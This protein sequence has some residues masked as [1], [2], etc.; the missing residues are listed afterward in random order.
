M[1]RPAASSLALLTRKPEDRRCNEVAKALSLVA[2][3]R[4]AF[5][6]AM[7]VLIVIPIL[8]LLSLYQIN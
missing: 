3:L 6:D 1:A 7:L 5:K 4:W 8:E 2:A